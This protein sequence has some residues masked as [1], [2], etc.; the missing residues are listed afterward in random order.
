M[1]FNSVPVIDIAPFMHGGAAGKRAVAD[2][3][4]R[5]CEEIGFFSISGHGV[6]EDL[7]EEVRRLSFEFFGRPM[8]VKRQIERP[9]TK[10][11]RGYSWVGDR[12]LAYS[13][14]DKTPPDLQESFAMGPI[15]GAPADVAGTPAD[16]AFYYSN[17]WPADPP[18]FREAFEAYYLEM[19]RVAAQVLRI[20][21]VALDLDEHHFDDKVDKHTSTMRAIRYPPLTGTPEPGQLRAG[22]HT[23]YGTLTVLRGDDV[24]GGLQVRL[25]NGEWVNVHPAPGTFVC[26]IG[27]LMRRWTNDRW[28]SNLHRVAVPP[29]EFAHNERLTLVFFQNPN[30]DAEIRCIDP[31]A[32]AKH[33][34]VIFG[35]YYLGKHMKAQHLTTTDKAGAIA[36]SAG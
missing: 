26:N 21:A 19:E 36:K 35:D 27:D 2:Q 29:P 16:K 7:V 12:G 14:G 13:L 23:D 24:P 17:M 20:F 11:S 32:P 34:P 30:C 4:R 15:S 33:E 3:V 1:N 22:E 18:R 6:S 31:N 5:A 10:I 9:P 8:P 25:L 28:N